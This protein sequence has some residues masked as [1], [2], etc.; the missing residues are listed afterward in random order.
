MKKWKII[1]LSAVSGLLIAGNLY[2][3]GKEDSKIERTLYVENWTKAKLGDVSRT[4]QTQGMVVPYEEYPAYF[5]T[6]NNSKNF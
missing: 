6:K 2:L 3:I 4:F 1:S 5:D